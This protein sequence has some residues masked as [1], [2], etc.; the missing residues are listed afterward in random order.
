MHALSL[1]DTSL[2]YYHV[3]ILFHG[4]GNCSLYDTDITI[5]NYSKCLA[6]NGVLFYSQC[7]EA[8]TLYCIRCARV[9]A[10][11]NKRLLLS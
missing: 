9:I 2:E 7:L 10:I 8:V 4:Y 6:F 1:W 11:D 5:H 3:S